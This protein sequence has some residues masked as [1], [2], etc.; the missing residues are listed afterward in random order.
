M[1]SQLGEQKFETF[2]KGMIPKRFVEVVAE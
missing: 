1:T 2:Y